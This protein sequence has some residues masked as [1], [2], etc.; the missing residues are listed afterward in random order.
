LR[1][2][3]ELYFPAL[4]KTVDSQKTY[5]KTVNEKFSEIKTKKLTIENVNNEDLFSNL[6]LGENAANA[7]FVEEDRRQI[8]L[9][10]KHLLCLY[11]YRDEVEN[12]IKNK[13]MEV[14]PNLSKISG[15]TLAAKLIEKAG[16]LKK[17]SM[18]PSS[19]IQLLG[20]EKALFRTKKFKSKPPKHGLIFQHPT[21][22]SKPRKK[23]GK[24]ARTLA[25]KLAIAARA[26]YFSGN[27]IIDKLELE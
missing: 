18:M 16:S 13:V 9:L 6:N 15:P 5:V 10:S 4:S 3:C 11:D 20:A 21:V 26:D 2:W 17:L 1:E 12:Y 24:F 23:R 19:T 25:G 14:A 7:K 22:H 8:E 27:N